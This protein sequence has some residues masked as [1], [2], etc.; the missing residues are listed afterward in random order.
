MHSATHNA[1]LFKSRQI[2]RTGRDLDAGNRLARAAC[3]KIII[4]R[5]REAEQLI[6]F[7]TLYTAV[8]EVE[9]EMMKSY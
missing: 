2:V 3:S 5:N 8:V 1:P 7:L 4:V 9:I 6:H